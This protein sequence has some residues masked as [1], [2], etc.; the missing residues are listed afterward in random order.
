MRKG[1]LLGPCQ[2]SFT[3]AVSMFSG[4]EFRVQGSVISEC[5]RHVHDCVEVMSSLLG[6][7]HGT[8]GLSES[9]NA[10]THGYVS[11]QHQHGISRHLPPSNAS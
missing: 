6:G 4:S 5:L 10:S 3:E 1:R 11:C 2:E 8:D 9:W 7:Q